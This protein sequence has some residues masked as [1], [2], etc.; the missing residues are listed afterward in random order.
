M[1][2]A[3]FNLG[4]GAEHRPTCHRAFADAMKA[5]DVNWPQA[6]VNMERWL[7]QFYDPTSLERRS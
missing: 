5:F 7:D 4:V 3:V 2:I 6:G 1:P